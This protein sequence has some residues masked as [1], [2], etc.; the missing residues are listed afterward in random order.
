MLAS[1]THV[2]Y[3]LVF[4]Q[5]ICIS[6]IK[7]LPFF[8]GQVYT[9]VFFHVLV[10]SLLLQCMLC[11]R[12]LYNAID[13]IQCNTSVLKNLFHK[14]NTKNNIQNML[15][16]QCLVVAFALFCCSSCVPSRSTVLLLSFL[17][18]C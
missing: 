4:H 16:A 3:M 8:D 6:A 2:L 15:I 18:I 9:L 14:T 12:E 13:V 17:F 5:S 11:V 10:C 1:F 7:R